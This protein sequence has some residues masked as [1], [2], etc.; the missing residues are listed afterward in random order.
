MSVELSRSGNFRAEELM[1]ITLPWKRVEVI[2]GELVPMTPAGH[3]HN[4]VGHR[5]ENLFAEYCRTRPEWEFGGDTDAFLLQRDPDVLLSPD[6]SLFRV[7]RPP[8]GGPWIAGAPDIAAE[9]LSPSNSRTAILYKVRKYFAA[10]SAQV[11]VADPVAKTLDIYFADGRR[12]VARDGAILSAEA[13]AEGLRI[14]LG[15]PFAASRL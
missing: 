13:P 5:F 4:R 1:T 11:W 10:G 7:P 2:E 15:E 9:V 8:S 3:F 12:L 14:D 6:A